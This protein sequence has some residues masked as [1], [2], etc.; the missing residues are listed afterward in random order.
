MKELQRIIEAYRSIDFSL[1]KV[2]LATVVRVEGSS[3]RRPGAR[4]LITDDGKWVGAISGG[5]LEGDALRKAR[6]VMVEGIAAIVSYDTMDDGSENLGIGLGCNGIIDVLIEPVDP[7]DKAN[8][9]EILIP[10]IEIKNPEVLATVWRTEGDTG[11]SLGQRF[12]TL[13][14]NDDRFPFLQED[15]HCS[16]FNGRSLNKEYELASGRIEV[17]FEVIQPPLQLLI[18]GAGYDAIPVVKLAK[19][20]GWKVIVNDDCIAHINPKKFFEADQLMV[21]S[22]DY[23][24][25]DLKIDRHAA[26]LLISHNYKFDLSILQNLLGTEVGYIGI[27]GPRKRF[28]KMLKELKEK[29]ME[30]S[31]DDLNKIYSP[32]GLNIGA[33]TPDEIALSVIAEIRAVFSHKRGGHLK[34]LAG[35]IHERPDLQI[36]DK[37]KKV[38]KR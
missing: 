22:R 4:M 5:C 25:P 35:P 19:E 9:L 28:L 24:H 13:G 7:M 17:F 14:K 23:I 30:L 37:G 21:C 11:I 18:F 32:V 33:E 12:S 36:I 6:K 34:N 1:R 38:E 29:G 15:F 10:F 2:A 3:Y 16:K 26:A 8:P 27:L 20:L 31:S